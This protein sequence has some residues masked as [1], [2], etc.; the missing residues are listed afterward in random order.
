MLEE[1]MTEVT[2][3][4]R[5]TSLADIAIVRN[6]YQ[7]VKFF[8]KLLQDWIDEQAESIKED[9]IENGLKDIPILDDEGQKVA[10]FYLQE[11]KKY[12]YPEHIV[13]IEEELKKQKKIAELNG[14]AKPTSSLSLVYK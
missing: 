5:N 14:S 6:K 2:T 10:G 13:K 9:M 12:E 3:S 11:R 1:N 7:Q 8:I 4:V